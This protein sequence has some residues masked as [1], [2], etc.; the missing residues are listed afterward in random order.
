MQ[1]TSLPSAGLILLIAN[2][3]AF[4]A[5]SPTDAT[6][7]PREY[8]DFAMGHEGNPGRGRDVFNNPQRAACFQC[9]SVDGTASKAGP[10]LASVGDK[11]PRPDLIAAVLEPSAAIAVGYGTTIVETK[12]D[13]GFQGVIKEATADYLGLMGADGKHLRINTPDI[14]S[15]RQS[16][17]SL[18]PEGLQA[19]MSRQ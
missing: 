15:R 5:Q 19:G 9:H 17:G 7:P 8:R 18:M 1:V 4:A 13:E 11:Y 2:V 3:T 10:D 14:Q 16:I 12:S 6:L